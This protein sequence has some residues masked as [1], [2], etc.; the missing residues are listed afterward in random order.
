MP[1]STSERYIP[2]HHT[3]DADE[4]DSATSHQILSI[5]LEIEQANHQITQQKLREVQEIM[6]VLINKQN[7]IASKPETEEQV[8]TENTTQ[9]DHLQL[10]L[11]LYQ[12]REALAQREMKEYKEQNYT[13][14]EKNQQLQ[15]QIKELLQQ[16]QSHPTPPRTSCCP[17]ETPQS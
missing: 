3:M 13:L 6:K 1:P 11:E 16:L 5:K 12:D 15:R 10:Q 7:N 4:D 17:Y 14:Q 9:Q 2:P 8:G